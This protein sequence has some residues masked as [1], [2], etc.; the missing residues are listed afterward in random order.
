MPPVWITGSL[1]FTFIHLTPRLRIPHTA[2]S[3]HA[4]HIGTCG[5]SRGQGLWRLDNSLLSNQDYIQLVQ[6]IIQEEQTNP[7]L[8]DPNTLVGLAKTQN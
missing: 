6:D 8:E 2:L 5:P 1:R 3:D 4:V 7:Q